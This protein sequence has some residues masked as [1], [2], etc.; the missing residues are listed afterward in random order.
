MRGGVPYDQPR[1]AEK[2]AGLSITHY[3]EMGMNS[4]HTVLFFNGQSKVIAD[5]FFEKA[6]EGFDGSWKP[7]QLSHGE[8]AT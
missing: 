8:K 2:V 7:Y 1:R 5:I 4:M 6:P 3:E